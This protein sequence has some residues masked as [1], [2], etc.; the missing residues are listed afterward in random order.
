MKKKVP[1][2]IFPAVNKIEIGQVELDEC[3]SDEIVVKTHYTFASSG[4]ELRVLGAKYI[5]PDFF[6][7]VPG[8]SVVGQ[9][10]AVGAKAT[11][12]REGDWV[13]GR[14][15]KEVKSPNSAWGGQAAYHVYGTRTQGK[16]LLLWEGA[17]PRDYII[18][19]VSAISFRG[20]DSVGP[21][22]GETAVVLGQ[23]VIGAFSAAWLKAA[24]CRV[25]VTDV[26]NGRL[27]LAKQRGVDAVVNARESDA[28]ERIRALTNGGADIVV[29]ASGTPEGFAMAFQLLRAT[30]GGHEDDTMQ[31][32]PFYDGYTSR[33]VAQ[34]NYLDPLA[35]NPLA[36]GEG[37]FISVPRDRSYR[38]RMRVLEK[39]RQGAIKSA[40]F[41]GDILPWDRAPEAYAG[42][43]DDPDKVFSLTFD[44]SS[45]S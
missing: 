26:L 4:T 16:P 36:G 10:V 2:V 40:D 43:R 34:A 15:P 41:V 17:V 38:D 7:A 39:I 14:N 42:L 12:Y 35:V 24:G 31:N 28:V 33:L 44:W 27:A 45:V 5:S 1:A 22:L 9:V 6:P 25:I 8:Y 29:E 3:G 20:V 23:G 11:G 21:R 30:F 18:S 32:G 37:L 19:E 13:T